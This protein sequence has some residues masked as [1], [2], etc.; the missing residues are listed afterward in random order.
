MLGRIENLPQVRLPLQ[1]FELGHLRIQSINNEVRLGSIRGKVLVKLR[2]YPNYQY[3]EWV[4]L[5][6]ELKE[7]PV[8]EDFSYKEFLVIGGVYSLANY[9]KIER[10]KSPQLNLGERIVKPMFS[11]IYHLREKFESVINRSLPEPQASL[12][13]G[14]V[15]GIER[16]YPYDFYQKLRQA[17][18]LHVIVASGYNVLVVTGFFLSLAPLIGRR[19]IHPL[20][21]VGILIYAIMA[22]LNPPIVRAAI[23]GGVGIIAQGLGRQAHSLYW[24]SLTAL[25]MLLVNPLLYK[26]VSFQLS[27]LA[28]AGV[29]VVNPWLIGKLSVIPNILRES[30]STTLAVQML[31]WP[32]LWL[33]FHQFNPLALFANT[34]VLE[35]IP[36]IMGLGMALTAVGLFSSFLSGMIALPVWLL[37]EYFVK[38]VEF[39][40]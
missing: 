24:L 27:F 10:V 3:G 14:I 37:L 33:N 4:K 6:G 17:G 19:K 36:I 13:S 29:L 34:L 31:T 15:F 1:K 26:S 18:V 21:L 30:F 16:D 38:I 32:I 28:S 40:G 12:L 20:A 5:S 11:L 23:L 39:F 35:T 7:P 8:F 9:P 22:G 2:A 25:L